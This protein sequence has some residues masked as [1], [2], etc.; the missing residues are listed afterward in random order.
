M[1]NINWRHTFYLF[2]QFFV[3][4]TIYHYSF[5]LLTNFLSLVTLFFIFVVI[6]NWRRFKFKYQYMTNTM[7]INT[8][9]YKTKLVSFEIFLSY[10]FYTFPFRRT[11]CMQ[12]S[13][14]CR[15]QIFGKLSRWVM[16]SIMHVFQNNIFSEIS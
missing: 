12:M 13:C 5:R 15:E 14:Q 8:R 9:N 2:F 11:Q 6:F 10:N 16:H 3:C 7:F 4:R 1:L